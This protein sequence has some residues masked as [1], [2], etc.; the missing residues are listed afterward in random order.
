[1]D[2]GWL[3]TDFETLVLRQLKTIRE[4]VHEIRA[5]VLAQAGEEPEPACPNCGNTELEDTSTNAP[6]ITCVGE[7]GCGKSFDPEVMVHG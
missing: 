4:E 7:Q 1:M 3:L 6:R 2:R 5:L